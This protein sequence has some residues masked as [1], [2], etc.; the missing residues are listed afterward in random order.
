MFP[1]RYELNL[2]RKQR[3]RPW[4]SVV[5]TTQH[6]ISEKVGNNFVDKRRSLGRYSSLADKGRALFDSRRET[7]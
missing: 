7:P 1:A 5:L 3:I 4:G 2:N 6:L